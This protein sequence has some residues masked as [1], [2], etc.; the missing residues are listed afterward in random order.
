[1][2]PLRTLPLLSVAALMTLAGCS[3]E[4]PTQAVQQAGS[5]IAVVTTNSQNTEGNISMY[6]S[7][8]GITDNNLMTLGGDGVAFSYDS[9]LYLIDR[10]LATL[11]KIRGSVVDSQHVDYEI[12]VGAASNPQ[13]IAFAS[14]QKGYLTR[15]SALN[16]LIIN[17]ATG[18]SIGALSFAGYV[19]ASTGP[20]P[21][22]ASAVI[23]NG[24]LYVACQR[25]SASWGFGDSS[26]VVIVNTANDFIEKAVS[27]Y[28]YNPADMKAV[29]GK[30][31]VACS[32]DWSL[33]DGGIERIDLATGVNEGMI[34]SEAA[35]AGTLSSIE[36]VSASK[37]YIMVATAAWV[38]EIHPLNLTLQTLGAKLAF[39]NNAAYYNPV[40][41]DGYYA[42]I[43]D[44]G[45]ATPGLV[46]VDP[47]TD[48]Q[49]GATIPMGLLPYAL[50]VLK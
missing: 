27:L 1:M 20:F 3:K 9:N 29:D 42:Y 24:K 39:V 31:Y 28:N 49:V 35:M 38:N 21:M 11:R 48:A 43:G 12:N 7:A 4:K 6:R 23:S 22:M 30:L 8:T 32:G 47:A 15:L 25:L 44:R 17:P 5:A 26:L 34:M 18:D 19:N 10:T 13:A 41:F 2:N 46:K 45:G 37:A 36:I 14:P 16:L 40:V 50:S 33:M